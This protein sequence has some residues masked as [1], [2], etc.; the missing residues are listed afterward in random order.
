[1]PIHFVRKKLRR[2]RKS[3]FKKLGIKDEM[4]AKTGET[5]R[6][7]RGNRIPLFGVV[8]P[9]SGKWLSR[10]GGVTSKCASNSLVS[11]SRGN[12]KEVAKR[13]SK[14]VNVS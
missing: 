14:D 1:M 11:T 6:G 8:D 2:K 7:K 5:V 9:K 13:N 10:E 4:V 3:I 12:A